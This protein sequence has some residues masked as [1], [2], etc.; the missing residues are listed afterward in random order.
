MKLDAEGAEF[1][2]VKGLADTIANHRPILSI[3]VY[4]EWTKGFGYEPAD[5]LH[6]VGTLGYDVLIALGDN[7]RP[8]TRSV[9]A[10]LAARQSV[11]LICGIRRI[12]TTRLA[13]W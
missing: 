1:G 4:G 6:F 7:A 3:E 10:A 2:V 11:N 13:A 8:V 12:H 5:L 9:V